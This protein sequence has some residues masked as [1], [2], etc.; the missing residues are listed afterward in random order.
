MR[1][2]NHFYRNQPA[3]YEQDFN[4]GGHRWI[5]ANDADNSIFSYIRFAED[6]DD[7]LVII[8]NFT[9]QVRYNYR[10]G[11]PQDG[12]YREALNSDSAHYGGSNVGNNG[13]LQALAEHWGEWP[14]SLNL[15]VPPLAIVVLKPE[16]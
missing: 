9:P 13:G 3:L 8:L 14:Y 10:I 15:T 12:F 7:F 5:N 4:P 16:S 11:V 2:L 6:T 1:D